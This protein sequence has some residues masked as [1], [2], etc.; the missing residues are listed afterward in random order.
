[1]AVC[2]HLLLLLPF[3]VQTNIKLYFAQAPVC[4]GCVPVQWVQWVKNG[5]ETIYNI[6]TKC[7]I[8]VGGPRD[9][10]GRPQGTGP[11][12]NLMVFGSTVWLHPGR[13][14]TSWCWCGSS[15][16]RTS[17][18][19]L[20]CLW[21]TVAGTVLPVWP[22]VGWRLG[23]AWWP[24][25]WRADEQ[26]CPIGVCLTSGWHWTP[27]WN[28]GTQSWHSAVGPCP[29]C[30]CPSGG[31]GPTRAS[32]NPVSGVQALCST[33][34]LHCGGRIACFSVEMPWYY[35]PCV[36]LWQC[37]ETSSA[38]SVCLHQGIWQNQRSVGFVHGS[39]S[40]SL[41]C[42]FCWWFVWSGIFQGGTPST[43]CLPTS[44]GCSDHPA[45]ELRLWASLWSGTGRNRQQI[46]VPVT[47]H[48]RAGHY[49][50]LKIV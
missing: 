45:S 38:C 26:G 23:R 2:S 25:P 44:G 12:W 33:G 39:G 17:G 29:G 35:P 16:W 11:R 22:R 50:I 20:W 30:Q 41:W 43:I 28:L 42:F 48:S 21:R 1:M 15:L 8:A 27:D 4:G 5:A 31:E 14:R 3:N 46:V 7:L 24:W 10:G 34:S 37:E 32:S 9:F 36:L 6:Y 19:V 13:R 18:H 47:G 49:W 40:Q